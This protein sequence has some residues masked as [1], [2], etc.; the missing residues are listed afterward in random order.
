MTIATPVH[1]GVSLTQMLAA[2]EN[3]AARQADWLTHYQQPVI[4]L[5]LVA[6]GDIKDSLRY[7]N[8][9]GVALQ[10]CDQLLWEHRWQVLD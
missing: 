10:M 2:K 1:S 9:M 3:R 8:T 6:P 5:T 7:R 4:S